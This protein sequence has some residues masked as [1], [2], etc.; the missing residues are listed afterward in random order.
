VRY[1]SDGRNTGHGAQS[2]SLDRHVAIKGLPPDYAL[3]ETFVSRVERE[4]RTAAK[5]VAVGLMP[6][7]VSA[8]SF[9]FAIGLGTWIG[10]ANGRDGQRPRRPTAATACGQRTICSASIARAT[11]PMCRSQ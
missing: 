8:Q 2:E 9:A 11:M 1:R 4:A 10:T 7:V 5:L 3:D 6:G